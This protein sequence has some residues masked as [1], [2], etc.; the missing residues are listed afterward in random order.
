MK[1]QG[2]RPNSML[3][4]KD[5]KLIPRTLTKKFLKNTSGTSNGSE[6]GR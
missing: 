1:P 2:Y 5:I 3:T 4:T 6:S